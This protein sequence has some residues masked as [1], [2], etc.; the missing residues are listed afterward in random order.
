VEHIIAYV[1]GEVPIG[2]GSPEGGSP[3]GCESQGVLEPQENPQVQEPPTHINNCLFF[4]GTQDHIK[5]GGSPLGIP[6]RVLL[7]KGRSS[8][9]TEK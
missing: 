1:V 8:N 3:K 6:L 9:Y 4:I 2:V 5:I 7:P